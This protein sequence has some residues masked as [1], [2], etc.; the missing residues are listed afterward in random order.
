[1]I[2][3]EEEGIVDDVNSDY[4]H[5]EQEVSNYENATAYNLKNFI[6][7][8]IANHGYYIARYEASYGEDMK[9]NSKISTGFHVDDT[10]P[11]TEGYLWNNI[12]QVESSMACKRM[13]SS[14]HF[15]SDLMNSYAWDTAIVFIQKLGGDSYKHYAFANGNNINTN[16]TNTGVNN[17]EPLNI[18]DMAGNIREWTTETGSNQYA[19]CTIRGGS[20]YVDT[21]YTSYRAC[22]RN[23]SNDGLGFRPILY[24]NL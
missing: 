7:S 13:Y 10:K 24:I 14:S 22:F 9:P 3:S 20:Y 2:D 1:M 15:T 8:A 23:I 11:Q 19:S 17:D 12:T 18:N 16:M 21:V 4:T 5:S 6:D